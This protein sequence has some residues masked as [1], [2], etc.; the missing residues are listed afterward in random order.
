MTNWR[1]QHLAKKTEHGQ[2][3][4]LDANPM[5]RLR[6]LTTKQIRIFAKDTIKG[7][8]FGIGSLGKGAEV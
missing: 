8:V 1:A 3:L 7:R 4:Y 2:E 6:T 5:G